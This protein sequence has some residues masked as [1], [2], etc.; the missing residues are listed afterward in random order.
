MKEVKKYIPE[1]VYS[2][3]TQREDLQ[4]L[5][6][7]KEEWGIIALFLWWKEIGEIK[8][9]NYF[10]LPSKEF[11]DLFFLSKNENGLHNV[12]L[13]ISSRFKD[14]EFCNSLF[15]QRHPN[16]ESYKKFVDWI[17][18]DYQIKLK[19][20]YFIFPELPGVEIIISEPEN[21]IYGDNYLEISE[22]I[23]FLSIFLEYSKLND[24][25]TKYSI[26]INNIL[27][28]NISKVDPNKLPL[29]YKYFYEYL[30]KYPIA[31]SIDEIYFEFCNEK[32]SINL[33]TFLL[34]IFHSRKDLQDAFKQ[35]KSSL[36]EFL[37][38]WWNKFGYKEYPGFKEYIFLKSKDNKNFVS[39]KI[40]ITGFHN[41]QLGISEDARNLYKSIKEIT[42]YVKASKIPLACLNNEI[43]ANYK[44][45]DFINSKYNFIVLP[46]LEQLNLFMKNPTYFH[47]NKVYALM[48]WELESLPENFQCIFKKIDVV[49]APSKFLKQ[50]FSLIHK[51]VKL[52]PHFVDIEYEINEEKF[53]QFTFVYSADMNSYIARKNPLCV[54]RAFKKLLK[55]YLFKN[56]KKPRL[57]LRLTH[58]SNVKHSVIVE[59]IDNCEQIFL[60]TEKLAKKEYLTLLSRS[61]C[62]ISPHRSEGFGRN[63]AESMFLGTCTIVSNYSGNLDFCN[64]DTSYLIDGK[65]IKIN[66]GEYPLSDNCSWFDPDINHLT[67]LMM[68]VYVNYDAAISKSINAKEIIMANH[69]KDV[70]IKNLEIILGQDL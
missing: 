9:Y 10:W 56:Q 51:D 47:K 67:L 37:I 24:K 4:F 15:D 65:L 68:E 31:K 13:A 25:E 16:S 14:L 55:E 32:K 27:Y 45:Y 50:V 8:E 44:L 28:E 23:N 34:P 49:L 21:I 2:I 52:L 61:H 7:I 70:Y 46:P 30:K 39:E 26:Y 38:N 43:E 42:P 48:P 12:Y 66:K 29:I 36:E 3:Y 33:A 19:Y 18:G 69:S 64:K 40:A 17:I 58:F 22:E 20:T 35:Q 41:Y 60:L 57:I 53:D 5:F 1:F 62:Y 6:P 11:R 63:I 54:I 59:E